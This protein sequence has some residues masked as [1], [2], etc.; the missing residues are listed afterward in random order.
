MV[1]F[2]GRGRELG[3]LDGVLA[4]LT[5]G[6]TRL[7]EV[8]GEPGIGKTRLLA[9]LAGRAAA[10][11]WAV[12]RGVAS[13]LERDVPFGVLSDALRDRVPALSPEWTMPYRFSGGIRDTGR[14]ALER[15]RRYRTATIAIG[16]L[17]TG[18][19]LVLILDDVHW[20]D[21]PSL[22]LLA[23]LLRN[24]PDCT[25]LLA[26]AYR[27]RQ[28]G[29]R[30][31]A[32]VAEAGD[33]ALRL[34]LGPLSLDEAAALLGPGTNAAALYP[35]S[36]GNP[37]YLQALA[38]GTPAAPIEAAEPAGD[39]LPL[40][41][42]QAL[43]G[44]LST[45]DPGTRRVAWA[46]A[47]AGDPFEPWLVAA[48]AE[49]PDAAALAAI[50]TLKGRD[51]IR[52][53]E[54]PARFRFRHPLLRQVVYQAVPAGWRLAAHARAGTA[55]AAHDGPIA[56]RAHHVSR[57]AGRGDLAATTLLLAAARENLGRAPALAAQWLRRALDLVPE[58][59][60][61]AAPELT[62]AALLVELAHA[63]GMA[64]QLHEGRAAAHEALQALADGPGDARIRVVTLCATVERLLGRHAEARALLDR[65]LATLRDPATPGA[66]A[67][68]LELA[69]GGFMGADFATTTRYAARA[70]ATA[71][72]NGDRPI[73]A[74]ALGFLAMASFAA[75]DVPT[76]TVHLDEAAALVDAMADPE[77]AERVDAAL[78][79]GWNEIY[80]ERFPAA[81]RHLDRGRTLAVAS[82]Q[83]Y[84]LPLILVG[85][86]V[87]LRWLG[88]LP[89]AMACAQDAV[90]T[91]QIVDSDELRSV[92]LA[93]Q[94]WIA[95]WT[96]QL[97]LARAASSRAVR[98]GGREGGWFASLAL[99]MD[100]RSRIA[101]GDAESVG[102]LVER[103]GGPGLPAIDPWLRASWFEYLV[104]AELADDRT[105]RAAEWAHRA[106][107]SA[108]ELGLPAHTGLALLAEAHV[109]AAR[110]DAE[111]TVRSALAAG[112]QF[113][114]AGCR[115]DHGRALLLA[116]SHLAEPARAVPVLRRAKALLETCG[117]EG[118]R[119]EAARELRRRAATRPDGGRSPQ[120]AGLSA[121]TRH[122]RQVAE[123]VAAGRTNREIA[124]ELHVTVK[125]VE[126]HLSQIFARLGVG[127]R[128]GVAGVV[129]RGTG[130]D[131]ASS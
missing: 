61:D 25:L 58:Q 4:G 97:D 53:V 12:Y 7:V 91:A 66:P 27:P 33:D 21:E 75:M 131:S 128:A 100:V 52:P 60:P 82:G 1:A 90:D 96:D 84:V 54:S 98:A 40:M 78:W 64:G 45:I 73:Q 38:V 51:L 10:R 18:R 3:L 11:G 70:L 39:E 83:G 79:L 9:E 104:R 31:S 42:R 17:A 107:A 28:A 55:L 67:L 127:N 41:V 14:E 87:V 34:E 22:E 8:V 19:G 120:P 122:Q 46:A 5:P 2:V 118:L 57:S 15:Y 80:L 65:E 43:L 121:L 59:P 95:T 26:A 112:A 29:P 74:T 32:A 36:G 108:D 62:R 50:D 105:D 124:A 47:V 71:R 119:A 115:L 23:H 88:E 37:F 102:T 63:L 6:T 48:V 94:S 20:A 129:A 110:G 86:A 109:Y 69:I 35:G 49:I 116:G 24:P 111:Q 81:L 117:A 13:E 123:L 89:D 56:A 93:V 114:R 99:A 130:Q 92:A 126:G 30:L 77:L 16:V 113:D 106:L 76:A 72:R 103:F 44:E 68:Q 85:L 125:T 101:V